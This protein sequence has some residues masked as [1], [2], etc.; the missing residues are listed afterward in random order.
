MPLIDAQVKVGQ[1]LRDGIDVDRR[2]KKDQIV[3]HSRAEE[4]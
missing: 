4:I 1:G 2:G 3:V